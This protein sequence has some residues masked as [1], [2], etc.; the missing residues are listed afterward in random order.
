MA[1]Q[2]LLAWQRLLSPELERRHIR[3]LGIASVIPIGLRNK[4]GGSLA[5]QYPSF[6]PWSQEAKLLRGVQGAFFPA[7]CLKF[8]AQPPPQKNGRSNQLQEKRLTTLLAHSTAVG[9]VGRSL[10]MATSKRIWKIMFDPVRLQLIWGEVL[11]RDWFA[12]KITSLRA[13]PTL[14]THQLTAVTTNS[15]AS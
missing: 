3:I 11:I 1:R 15:S 4:R 9:A 13:I 10:A 6:Q 12:L 8:S 2:Q 14:H 7:Q 5:S